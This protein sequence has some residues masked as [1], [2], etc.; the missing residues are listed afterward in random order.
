MTDFKCE[1]VSL[2]SRRW[3]I[4]LMSHEPV[5][6]KDTVFMDTCYLQEVIERTMTLVA[7]A[8][9]MVGQPNREVL[10]SIE[11]W[12]RKRQKWETVAQGRSRVKDRPLKNRYPGIL[13]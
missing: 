13:R 12:D 3:Q 9:F 5:E 4:R 6:L 2:L 1:A 8:S 11:Q 7:R 10:W